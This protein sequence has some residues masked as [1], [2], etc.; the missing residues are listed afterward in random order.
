MDVMYLYNSSFHC[1]W[2]KPCLFCTAKTTWICICVYVF[3]IFSCYIPYLKARGFGVLIGFSTH[4]LSLTGQTTTEYFF[5]CEESFDVQLAL[6]S[7]YEKIERK[8]QFYIFK[9][10]SSPII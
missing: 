4:M 6:I 10:K 7:N 9:G 5:C 3:A 8:F 2:I 1:D